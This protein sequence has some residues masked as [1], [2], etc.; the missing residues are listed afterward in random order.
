M[1]WKV[2]PASYVSGR[3]VEFFIERVQNAYN[4]GG[5]AG[6]TKR[7]KNGVGVVTI[8]YEIVRKMY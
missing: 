2:L 8:N 4:G 6:S 7:S 5:N 1:E 3:A